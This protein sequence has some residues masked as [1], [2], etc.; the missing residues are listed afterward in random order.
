[1][2][3]HVAANTGCNLGCEYCYEEPDREMKEEQI[4]NEY[5]LDLIMERLEEFSEKYPGIDP[6]L[7]G[8]EP[9][10]LP[11]EDLRKLYERMYELYDL[12]DPGRSP[13]V[14]TNG[15][16]ITD[17]HI[18]LFKEFDVS[19]G[20]SM[21]GPEELNDSRIARSGGEDVT[22][23]MTEQTYE[24]I[25]KI[26]E[27][28]ELQCGIICVLSK[29]N[30]GT[31]EKLEKLLDWLDYLNKNDVTGH[32]NPAIPYEDV[33]E[34]LSLS[35]ERLKEVFIS[36][37]EWMQ[38]EP[39]RQW[40]PMMDYQENLLA[41]K[42]GNCVNTKCDVYNAESAKIIRGDGD[43]TACGKTWGAVGDGVPF[44]QGDSTGNEYGE[45]NERYNMLRQLPG[46]YSEEVQNGEVEDQGGCK[47]CRYWAVCQGGCPAAGGE[48]DYRNRVWHCEAI[49][50]LYER[51]ENDMRSMFPAIRLITDLHNT[52]LDDVLELA[53][54]I[55][56][57]RTIGPFD[58]MDD[59]HNVG[60][61]TTIREHAKGKKEVHDMVLGAMKFDSIDDEYRA[62]TSIYPEEAVTIDDGKVSVDKNLAQKIK[63]GDHSDSQQRQQKTPTGQLKSPSEQEKQGGVSQSDSDGNPNEASASEDDEITFMTSDKVIEGD[64]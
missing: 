31:N 32:Y 14:Q 15:T 51:I 37:W 55:K 39:Y 27:E 13:H 9:L 42:L 61:R 40:D 25:R 48:Y 26:I 58:A 60:N 8:G 50:G 46:K 62:V 10:L 34:D 2:A 21:D 12:S 57:T 44:L 1:M 20:I 33:Q 29:T 47:G 43:T 30:A 36:T 3:T 24:S 28:P 63:E 52:G 6:G 22:R 49:Y 23:K 41:M 35:P 17:E 54:G 53:E 64:D 38:E 16:L 56:Q 7:H 5:D 11:I 45:T 19:I 4:D 59:R 18:E